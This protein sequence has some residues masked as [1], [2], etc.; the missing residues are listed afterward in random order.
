[1][2]LPKPIQPMVAFAQALRDAGF[3]IAPDQTIGF[4]TAVGLL[5][6]GDILDIH[7][8]GLALFAIPPERRDAYEAVFRAVFMDQ[9]MTPPAAGEEDEEL[10]A[11]EPT[12]DESDVEA[13]DDESEIGGEATVSERLGHRALTAGDEARILAM[14]ARELPKRLPQRMSYRRRRAKSGSALDIRRTLREAAKFDG[15]V[16][17]IRQTDRKQ[18]ARKVLLLVDVSGSMET[19]TEPTL[20]LAHALVQSAERAEVFTLGTRLTRVTQAL[21]PTDRAQ[22]LAR[23]SALIAD[24]DGG[25]RLGAALEAFLA[26]P[27]YSAFARGAA[28]VVISD[29]LEREAPEALIAATDRLSRLAWRLDW[30]SP[31]AADPNYRPETAAMTHI[32]AQVTSLGDGSNIEGVANHILN[33]ARAA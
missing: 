3:A 5:G 15:E 7:K 23:S 27:R 10:Q 6:P 12:G 32:A 16:L 9:V 13:E 20:R 26:I 28:V 33:L 11:H 14:F 24:I 30:L 21:Q 31:L 22:A 25:T 2:S 4:I 18:R 1:M 19:G 29:G 8:A 17:R